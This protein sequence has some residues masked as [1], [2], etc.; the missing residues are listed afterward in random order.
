MNI[1]HYIISKWEGYGL[2]KIKAEALVWLSTRPTPNRAQ[3]RQAVLLQL[4]A[5]WFDML[6]LVDATQ[7][8]LPLVTG[9]IVN[10]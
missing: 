5:K 4:Q 8:L 2:G 3:A 7:D 9:V 6:L 10:G 1:K